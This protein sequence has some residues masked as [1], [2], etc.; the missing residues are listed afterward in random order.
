M[1]TPP[2]SGPAVDGSGWLTTALYGASVVL[3]RVCPFFSIGKYYVVAQPVRTQRLL[4]EK[5]GKDIFVQQIDRDHPLISRLPRPRDEIVRRFAGGA[6]CFL[7]TRNGQ[8]IGHL[9]VT[10]S[11]YREPVHRSEFVMRP[12]DGTAWDFDMWVSEDERL[13]FAF[14][15]LWDQCNAYLREQGVAWTFSRVSAF[16]ATSLKAHQRLGM[17]V[18]HSLFYVTAGSV[19]L[20]IANVA[21]FMALSFSSRRFPAIALAAPMAR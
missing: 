21:P 6:Q 16:N 14:S 5:R 4:P 3:Q 19:E 9:W 13:G 17:T 1:S 11:A 18:M 20:L 15:R 12:G 10:R 8:T 2:R 7:A